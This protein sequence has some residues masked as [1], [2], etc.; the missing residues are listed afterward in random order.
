M[1]RFYAR[2]GAFMFTM[3]N[4]EIDGRPGGSVWIGAKT[5]YPLRFV[6]PFIDKDWD[7]VAL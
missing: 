7:Y 2:G 1:T 4:G 3:S 6:K 5:E